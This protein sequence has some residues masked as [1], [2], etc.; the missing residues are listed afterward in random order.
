MS[1][2]DLP[3]AAADI[4]DR[5]QVVG[6]AHPKDSAGPRHAYLWANGVAHDLGTLGGMNSEAIAINNRGQVVGWAETPDGG[7]H[8][9]L[10]E[11]GTMRDIGPVGGNSGAWGINERGQVIGYL[12][13]GGSFVW[14]RGAAQVLPLSAV[15]LN[16]RGL[17]AGWV[18]PGT[19]AIRRYRGVV[20]Q[21]GVVTDLGTLGGDETW[22]LAVSNSGWVAGAS[23]TATG[24]WHAF[25]W[26]HG[27][28][29]DL[30]PPTGPWADSW[31]VND[32]GD[33]AGGT[34]TRAFLWE[35]AVGEDIG[36]PVSL[37]TAVS[38]IN[39]RGTIAG[40]S[41]SNEQ[42][43]QACIWENGVRRD[44]GAGP[45]GYSSYGAAI[46]ERGVVAGATQ[47]QPGGEE[48]PS[49]WIPVEGE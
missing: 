34:D 5:N 17:V 12:V 43:R 46:N 20:W 4:N 24:D 35:D 26:K 31:L 2:G 14:E 11:R 25:R 33:V 8:A 37:S 44:L 1:L 47:L 15:A 28:M 49:I 21:D 30:V 6:V 38:G 32:R 29:E 42:P 16:D 23:R 48:I 22:A 41:F 36:G 10:W 13:G 18:R 39:R 9:F 19:G 40:T 7:T 27:R 45:A 3:G